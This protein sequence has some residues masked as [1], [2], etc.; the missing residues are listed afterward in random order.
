MSSLPWHRHMAMRFRTTILTAGRTATGIEV[1]AEVVGS[2]GT[3]KRPPVRVTINGHTYRS[4]IAVM[5]GKYM[6]GVSA[7]HRAGAGVAGGDTVD[8]R[9]APIARAGSSG[10]LREERGGEGWVLL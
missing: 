5:G 6:V 10:A 4:T 2:L 9:R 7:E 1:P 3:S 8:A